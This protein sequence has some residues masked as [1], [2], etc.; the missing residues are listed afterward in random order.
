[1][2]SYIIVGAFNWTPLSAQSGAFSMPLRILIPHASVPEISNKL[3]API[4][5]SPQLFI[6]SALLFREVDEI[7]SSYEIAS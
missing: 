3:A 7:N 1:M 4:I 6:S 2:S 5:T